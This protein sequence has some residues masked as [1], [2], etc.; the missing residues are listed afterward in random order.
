MYQK[1][2]Y[3]QVAASVVTED[4]KFFYSDVSYQLI[5]QYFSLC[6]SV[7]RRKKPITLHGMNSF[8]MSEVVF[9]YKGRYKE[10]MIYVAHSSI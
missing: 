9:L 8:P 1:D 5:I 6:K 2:K 10:C 3:E 4:K 7:K